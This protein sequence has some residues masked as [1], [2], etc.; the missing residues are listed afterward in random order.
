[1]NN[2]K[3][4]GT[5]IAIA[6]RFSQVVVDLL[7]RKQLV[8]N[9]SR[10][11]VGCMLDKMLFTQ[12]ILYITYVSWGF[13]ERGEKLVIQDQKARSNTFSCGTILK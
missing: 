4:L 11:D 2:E 10:A 9:T 7:R 3:T 6:R 1:M 5:G 13:S 12:S 8:R